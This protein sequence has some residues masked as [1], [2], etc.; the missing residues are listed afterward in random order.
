MKRIR[1]DDW[2]WMVRGAG[3]PRDQRSKLAGRLD[4]GQRDTASSSRRAGG[5]RSPSGQACV[6]I[7]GGA[8]PTGPP[9]H[10]SL[11]I[12][13]GRTNGATQPHASPS[14]FLSGGR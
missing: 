3:K 13:A 12:S 1:F 8:T 11:P 9:F 5:Q 2:M 14:D 10:A 4:K 6:S 7:A